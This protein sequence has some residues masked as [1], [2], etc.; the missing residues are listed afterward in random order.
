MSLHFSNIELVVFPP[1]RTILPSSFILG[2]DH[3][4]QEVAPVVGR[5][6]DPKRVAVFAYVHV[7]SFIR[8][9]A[10]Q[11]YPSMASRTCNKDTVQPSHGTF[12]ILKIKFDGKSII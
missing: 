7:Y 1:D 11:P 10:A 2:G 8:V 5:L 9:C 4:A 3:C 6:C 12:C